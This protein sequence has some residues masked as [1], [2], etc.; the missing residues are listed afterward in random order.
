MQLYFIRWKF[1]VKKC[2]EYPAPG[3]GIRAGD[4]TK[5]MRDARLATCD[6]HVYTRR[7]AFA[8]DSW[9]KLEAAASSFREIDLDRCIDPRC[10]RTSDFLAIVETRPRCT[11]RT[12]N[13]KYMKIARREASFSRFAK[14]NDYPFILRR[15]FS[16][17]GI[18]TIVRKIRDSFKRA[19]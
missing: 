17:L 13:V 2:L 5:S 8:L 3:I 6:V 4:G 14:R 12:R 11:R 9:E 7:S 18:A 16:S 1:R 15:D 10:G 19:K